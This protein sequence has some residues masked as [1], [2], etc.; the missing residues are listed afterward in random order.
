[1]GVLVISSCTNSL[2]SLNNR[3]LYLTFLEAGK[4]KVMVLVNLVPG[5]IDHS[6]SWHSDPCILVRPTLVQCNQQTTAE[7][8]CYFCD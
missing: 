5:K 2:G 3:N 7:M 8:I 6:I 4:S 1:M